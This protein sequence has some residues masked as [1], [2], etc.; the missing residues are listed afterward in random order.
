MYVYMINIWMK[1]Y[2]YRRYK[3]VS[4]TPESNNVPEPVVEEN[5]NV[6]DEPIDGKFYLYY[7]FTELIWIIM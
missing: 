2:I 4:G 5:P 6:S 3:C 1:W 7:I